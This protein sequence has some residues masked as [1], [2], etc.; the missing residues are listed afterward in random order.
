MLAGIMAGSFF[1]DPNRFATYSV[2]QVFGGGIFNLIVG[3]I[4]LNISNS[5]TSY[6]SKTMEDASGCSKFWAAALLVV[7]NLGF[8]GASIYVAVE[9]LTPVFGCRCSLITTT[10]LV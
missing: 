3:F 9:V 8:I 1:I 7:L 2:V 5:V 10:S 6:F 4:L